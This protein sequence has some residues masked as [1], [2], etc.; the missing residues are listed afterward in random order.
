MTPLERAAKVVYDKFNGQPDIRFIPDGPPFD[1]ADLTPE[2][3]APYIEHARAVLTAI[4]EP[5][6]GMALISAGYEPDDLTQGYGEDFNCVARE[7]A[8][9]ASEAWQAMI[10]AALAEG[11]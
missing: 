9:Q 2:S 1:W 6:E 10:D 4:R 3:K 7:K 5:S 8:G 11:V